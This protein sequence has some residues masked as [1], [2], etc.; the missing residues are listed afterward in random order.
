MKGRSICRFLKLQILSFV[1]FHDEYAEKVVG[2]QVEDNATSWA[3]IA[4]AAAAGAAV[5]TLAQKVRNALSRPIRQNKKQ[6]ERCSAVQSCR[7]AAC[8]GVCRLQKAVARSGLRY[9]DQPPG[10]CRFGS[11]LVR[12]ASLAVLHFGAEKYFSLPK[13]SAE[14]SIFSL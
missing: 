13:G 5:G 9:I 14:K 8:K 7:T 2:T 12:F 11:R 3:W 4:C 6:C 1:T 10:G